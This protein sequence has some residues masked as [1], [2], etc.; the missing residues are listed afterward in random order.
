[1]HHLTIQ[2]NHQP[3]ETVFQFII[4]TIVYSSTCF[5]RFTAHHQELNDC[6]GSLWFYLRF[7][8]I[9]ALCSP[10]AWMFVCCE[11]RVLSGR[12]LCN[13]LITRPEESY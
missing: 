9:V 12:G 1:M 4:L 2:K 7:V 6:S 13:E 3:D 8:V 11:C 10:G 5:V